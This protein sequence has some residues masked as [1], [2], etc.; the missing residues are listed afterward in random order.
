MIR[1]PAVAGMFYPPDGDILQ[2]TIKEYLYN[3]AEPASCESLRAIIVPHAGYMYSGQVAAHG[4]KVLSKHKKKKVILIGPAHTVYFDD[5][6]TDDN[7]YWETPLGQVK[8]LKSTFLESS[9]AHKGEHSLE[10]QV[11]FLQSVLDEFELLPL[12]AGKCDPLSVSKDIIDI[13]DDETVI[14]I[15]SDLSHFKEYDDAVDTDTVTNMAI[16]Q[17]DIKG[18]EGKGD[19]CGKAPILIMMH[20]AKQFGWRCKLLEYKNSGD[21]TGDHSRVVGYSSFA[22]GEG[23][24][25]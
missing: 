21:V 4:Y 2:L 25:A 7:E 10:V 20:I 23:V 1:Q 3:V 17:L 8:I 11:P 13:Y 19:A 12:I 16:E 5:I 22:I 18:M 14:V 15:S 9:A 24:V 6:V